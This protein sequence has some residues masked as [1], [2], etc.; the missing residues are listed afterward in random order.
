VDQ[1]LPMFKID[2]NSFS[3]VIRKMLGS[4]IGCEQL[5]IDLKLLFGEYIVLS[6]A[7]YQI[8]ELILKSQMRNT[9]NDEEIIQMVNNSCLTCQIKNDTFRLQLPIIL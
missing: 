1:D 9:D 5:S 8:V 6:D 4:F 7:R 3:K 2:Q